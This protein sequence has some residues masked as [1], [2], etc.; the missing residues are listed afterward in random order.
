MNED[1]QLDLLKWLINSY[2]ER[3]ASVADRSGTLLSADSI[4]LAATTILIERILSNVS[5]Y[6]SLELV[7]IM[8]AIGSCLLL[9][10]RSITLAT[11]GIIVSAWKTSEQ[12]HGDNSPSRLYFYPRETF[13]TF[14]T[15]SEFAGSFQTLSKKKMIDFAQGQLWAITGEYHKRYQ[16]LR[17]AMRY[18]LISI[19]PFIVSICYIFYKSL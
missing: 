1:E 14:K 8:V 15:F 18:F 3:R 7:V 19:A 6:S 9:L 12:V 11:T 5:S 16:N 4:L 13:K 2:D 10:I 17:Q